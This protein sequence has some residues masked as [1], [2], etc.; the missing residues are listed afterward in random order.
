MKTNDI[1]KGMRIVLRGT[2]WLATMMDNKKG[3]IRC[4]DVEGFFHEMGDIYMHD[5]AL[6]Q[7]PDGTWE[8]VEHT[9][10]QKKLRAFIE[11]M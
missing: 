9:E 7:L 11:S 6:V 4:A 10:E 5:V 1:K 3:N 8:Y 2:G